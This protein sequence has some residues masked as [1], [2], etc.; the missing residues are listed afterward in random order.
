MNIQPIIDLL[1]VLIWPLVLL[2]VLYYFGGPLK[3][4]LS[5]VSEITFNFAGVQATAKRQQIEAATLLGA[6]YQQNAPSDGPTI[7][8]NAQEI[9]DSVGKAGT[10]QAARR[11]SDARVLWVDDMPENNIY[12]RR[13][14]QALGLRFTLSTSTE[15]ALKKTQLSQYDVIISDMGRS[16]D[17]RAGYTLLDA[18]RKGG[19]CTPFI[20]Y[21]GSNAPQHK[22]EAKQHGAF[23][24]TS[25][26]DELFD[27]TISAILAY[28]QS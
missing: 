15:D 6:A 10:P 24:S 28:E 19:N 20:I 1:G 3:R 16:S 4:F 13:A 27:L 9:A 26:P 22:A 23:G 8:E 5:N 7:E 11:L 18:L 14:L 25:R 12:E 21:S 2:F 17:P